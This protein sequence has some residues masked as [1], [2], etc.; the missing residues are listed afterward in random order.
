MG[1]RNLDIVDKLTVDDHWNNFIDFCK[2]DM[3]SGGP[4]AHMTLAGHMSKGL[5]LLE[6]IWHSG[7][8][9][10]V[11]NVP[12]A[13]LLWT[14]FPHK[15]MMK[16][17]LEKLTAWL[18]ENWTGIATRRER[19]CVRIPANMAFYLKNFAEWAVTL[20][21]SKFYDENY[22]TSESRYEELW[23]HSQKSVKFLGRYSGFKFL[24][25][26]IRYCDLPA[27]LPDIRPKGGWSP[28][29]M[30]AIL[31]P[32]YKEVLLGDDSPKNLK[33]VNAIAKD[34]LSILKEEIP[35][36]DFFKMEVFL[37]D[38]K[39]CYFGR[40][41]YPGRSQDSEIE[42]MHKLQN[43]W[44]FDFQM[45]KAR[46]EIFPHWALGELNGWSKVRNELGT[47]LHDHGYM[48]SDSLYDYKNTIDLSAP[49]SKV[50][51]L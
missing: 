30:L 9:A 51:P 3:W 10:G 29:S 15:K 32:D 34:S 44:D 31:Y 22:G 38:Y 16:T 36:M 18:I 39:Q 27:K 35:E 1:H 17:S 24:E 6:R 21:E 37:C 12:T 50:Y 8:Y 26:A 23:E 47:V 33:K 7:V 11:Y 41:Q 13:E 2:Y 19:K 43:F 28:R 5:P 45:V 46:A 48:W 49:T 4:D 40:R 14:M 25:S 20:E 42:Y